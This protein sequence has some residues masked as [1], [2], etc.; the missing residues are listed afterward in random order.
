VHTVLD[1]CCGTGLLAGELAGLGYHVTGVDASPEMLDV[2]RR[3]LGHAVELVECRLPALAVDG[4][5]DAAVST[6]DGL[7]YLPPGAFDQTIAAVAAQLRPRGWLV[8]DLHTD[9]MLDF[10]VANPVVAGEEA[11]NGFVIST[12]FDT[13][14]RACETTIE[15]TRPSDGEPFSERHLQWFHAD[16]DV[17]AALADAGFGSV[18]VT[19]EYTSRPADA[20]TLRATWISRLA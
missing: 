4:V 3:R 1:L 15:V 10:T 8:F 5:F 14:G 12:T 19:D 6:F 20:T 2:A 9:A 18:A 16:S 11:G 7:N 13:G 17:R